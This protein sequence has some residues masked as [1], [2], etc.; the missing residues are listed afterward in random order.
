MKK[1][2][3]KKTLLFRLEELHYL[4]EQDV[5]D[6]IFQLAVIDSLLDYIYDED[7]RDKVERVAM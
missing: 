3:T 1:R 4:A 2:M 5:I 7:I 6:P